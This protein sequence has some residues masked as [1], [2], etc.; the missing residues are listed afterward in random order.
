MNAGN[1]FIF[2]FGGGQLDPKKWV[3]EPKLDGERVLIHVESRQI[4]NRKLDPYT[5]A[6]RL[7]KSL[8]LLLKQLEPYYHKLNDHGRPLFEWID[9]E[10]LCC[11]GHDLADGSLAVID[12]DA[13]GTLDQRRLLFDHLKP[14]PL[15]GSAKNDSVYKMPRMPIAKARQLWFKTKGLDSLFE[16]V[17]LKHRESHY[18]K[19]FYS[20]TKESTEWL[21]HRF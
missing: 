3:V 15:T 18:M 5:K 19:E 2:G 4:F 16:G 13:D 9:A 14:F 6:D 1:P 11:K 10:A 8:A 7:T 20:S 21:K 17:V 12:L